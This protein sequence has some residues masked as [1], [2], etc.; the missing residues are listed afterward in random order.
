M[1]VLKV[2]DNIF[3]HFINYTCNHKSSMRKIYLQHKSIYI[4]FYMFKI[5][6]DLKNNRKLCSQHY[7]Y[8]LKI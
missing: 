6:L 4:F 3:T 2:K 1:Y 5:A 8:N 7:I